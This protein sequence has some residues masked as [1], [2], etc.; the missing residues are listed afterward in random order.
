M[1]DHRIGKIKVRRGTNSQ[2]KLV[3]FEE[4]EL[5]YSI[6]KQRLYIGN[7][8]EKGGILV[9]NRNYIKNSVGVPPI[10]PDE[11]LHGDII[12]D[13]SNSKT[14]ITKCVESSCELLLI[15]DPNCCAILQNEINDLRDRI[16][17]LSAC[18]TIIPPPVIPPPPTVVPPTIFPPTV[19]PTIKLAWYIEPSDISVNLTE[20]V[21]FSAFAIGGIDP[22]SYKWSR[23]DGIPLSVVDNQ[24]T[25]TITTQLSDSAT[26]YCVANNSTESIT[27][28]DAVLDILTNSI[29]AEDGTFVL[30]ELSEFINWEISGFIV[31]TITTQPKSLVT[32]TLVPVTFEVA[33]TGTSPLNYQWRINGT[34]IT[35]ETNSTYTINN[36]TKDIIGINCVVSNLMGIANSNTVNLIVGI[37]PII[38][39]QPISQTITAGSPVTFSVV[40]DG[41]VPL[42]YQWSKNGTVI[43]GANS[44]NY[45]INSVTNSDSG[46]YSCVVSNSY[47]SITSD[48]ASLTV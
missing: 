1:I 21:T 17:T 37:K 27:S 44:N 35:G 41:S 30:S 42:A 11:A 25:L 7:G 34:A 2:R 23:K 22:V 26:Y 45:I 32:T 19:V 46:S 24:M 36:P 20:T 16:R 31:P 29:L 12:Y 9:S 18:A 40:A 38:I 43:N 14:Y 6:D 28:K 4:G 39:T 10:V 3:T 47:G 15:A 13:K 8:K 33:A 48:T 5:V